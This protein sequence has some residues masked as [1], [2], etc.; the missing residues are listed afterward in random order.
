MKH[1]LAITCCLLPCFTQSLEY[2][3]QHEN[4]DVR[5]SKIILMPGEEVGLHRDEHPRTV[6]GLKGG[7]FKRIEEDGSSKDIVFLTGE[8]IFFEA[9]PVGQKHRGINLSKT[10]LELI[11]VEYKTAA[12]PQSAQI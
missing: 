12:L 8:A 7:T 2:K 3:I 1:F 9:D 11:V 6:I 4:A 10:S 5:V